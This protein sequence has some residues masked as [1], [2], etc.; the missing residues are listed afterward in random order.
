MISRDTKI[1]IGGCGCGLNGCLGF[2]IVNLLIGSFCARY[3]LW[4]WL[5][6]LHAKYPQTIGLLD[7]N[8]SVW[9]LKMMVLGL[10]GGELFIPGAIITWLLIGL[11][12]LQ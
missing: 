2:L 4:H 7:P 6:I 9:S 11:S 8:T 1:G 10:F 5:P 12:I 3:C